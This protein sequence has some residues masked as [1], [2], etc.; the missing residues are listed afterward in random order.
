MNT[1]PQ[2]Q[3]GL[4]RRRDL[5]K[6]YDEIC[7]LDHQV[8][9][10]FETIALIEDYRLYWKPKVV[11]VILLAE[12][13]VQTS[14]SERDALISQIEPIAALEGCPRNYARFVYCL[15]YGESE[16]LST[17]KV[18][19]NSGTSQYWK[20]LFSCL[21]DVNPQDAFL[22]I[23]KRNR[24]FLQRIKNK[25][26]LLQGLRDSGIWLVDASIVAL[27]NQAKKPPR[28]K[29]DEIIR[30][31]WE[32]YTREWIATERPSKVIC[33]G[34]TVSMVVEQDARDL[35]GEKN[36]TA[37]DQPNAQ[38]TSKKHFENFQTVGSI[39]RPFYGGQF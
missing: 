19:K 31:S 36:Y 13:H 3:F 14:D 1:E 12:S 34:K 18:R 21:K 6:C 10:S 25:I 2:E 37:I 4:E 17:D 27:Y 7:Q 11:N 23:L 35:V 26:S 32:K 24:Q 33:V 39:C 15:G 9:E 5:R 38:I 16:L 8:E 20:L 29:L 30:V 22:P 28:R